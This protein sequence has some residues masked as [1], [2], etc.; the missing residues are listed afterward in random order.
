MSQEYNAVFIGG[1]KRLI[2][3]RILAGYRLRTE[4]RKHGYET[5]VVDTAPSMSQVEIMTL[6]ENVVTSKTL[7]LGFSITWIDSYNTPV[8][9]WIND[10]FFNQLKFKFPHIKIMSGGP[11]YPKIIGSHTIYNNSDWSLMGFSDVAY[12]KL[13]DM[14]SGK[15]NHGL[16]YFVD[17]DNGKKIVQS[18]IN[19]Q[20]NHPND[21][22]TVLELEDN[23]LPYQ[24]VPLEV[25]RGCI[26]RCSFCSHPFQ[27]AKEYDSYQRTPESIANE[28]KRN[29]DLFGTTKYI[30][31]DD[32]F[33]DSMEKLDRLHRAI[34]IAKLPDF[35]F[36]SYLKPE[37]LVTKPEMIDKLK[38]LGVTGGYIGLE[39]I[40]AE[41]RKAIKKGMDFERVV[42]AVKLLK[43][44]T[45]VKLYASFIVGLPG[46][47]ITSQFNTVKYMMDNQD[48]FC[49]SWGFEPLGMYVDKYG[50]GDSEMDNNPE[51][52]GYE[53]VDKKLNQSIHWKNKYMDKPFANN[54]AKALNQLSSRKTRI[55]GWAIATAWH[56][57]WSDEDIETNLGTNLDIPSR[58]NS[59]RQRAIA[60]LEKHTSLQLEKQYYM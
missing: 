7:I 29:Y 20:I 11:S 35:R 32:T 16:K 12:T 3:G 25:S 6:L 5:L 24:P 13:L 43:Q 53:I 39:S 47:S 28:L 49:A 57:G 55:G 40:N 52:F 44:K 1:N 50:Q 33:N 2:G 41:A 45:N 23:F 48:D 14:L 59:E 31:M 8:I 38:S 51:K 54:L 21:I 22:E 4:G 10:D 42:D 9:E 27:G 58:M 60:L 17:T 15:P 26:F 30:L 18:N 19:H 34:D 36:T 46:D 37:L 56:M